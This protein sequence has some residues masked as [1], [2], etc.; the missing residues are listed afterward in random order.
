MRISRH[1]YSPCT[2]CDYC[3]TYQSLT[4]MASQILEHPVFKAEYERRLNFARHKA[5][6]IALGRG[7]I[8]ILEPVDK[9][10]QLM[11][12]YRAGVSAHLTEINNR[13]SQFQTLIDQIP[14][15][16]PFVGGLVYL[17]VD[18]KWPGQFPMGTLHAAPDN[19]RHAFADHDERY[20]LLDIELVEYG[21]IALAVRSGSVQPDWDLIP[22]FMEK[23]TRWIRRNLP[24]DHDRDITADEVTALGNAANEIHNQLLERPNPLFLAPA[25]DLAKAHHDT[26]ELFEHRLRVEP[27]HW[28]RYWF[29]TAPSEEDRLAMYEVIRLVPDA[30]TMEVFLEQLKEVDEIQ[31][32]RLA[33]EVMHNR[34]PVYEREIAFRKKIRDSLDQGY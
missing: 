32:Q 31:G 1:H 17:Y 33:R 21:V 15:R 18:G 8:P 26:I 24:R 12:A 3:N 11:L 14:E 4:E 28:A 7:A 30:P 25:R 23:M 9:L 27:A 22:A 10:E 6:T 29:D 20:K 5:L 34:R 16:P 19:F 13:M 2:R